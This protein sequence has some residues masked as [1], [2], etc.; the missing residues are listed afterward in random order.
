M[1]ADAPAAA[2]VPATSADAE[3]AAAAPKKLTPKELRMLERAQ[4]VR[5]RRGAKPRAH[6]HAHAHTRALGASDP[7]QDAEEAA[8][9]A[10]AFKDQFGDLPLI[11][12]RFLSA[13]VWTR[14]VAAAPARPASARARPTR[15]P[16]A[17]PVCRT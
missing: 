1:S 2:P 14:C 9:K 5:V 16:R 6:A 11:Q 12:S 7:A 4:K 3:G 13:R 10:A 17:P 8:R 15:C